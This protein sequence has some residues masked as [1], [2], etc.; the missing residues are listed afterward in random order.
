LIA[1]RKKVQLI[2]HVECSRA[3]DTEID[4]ISS[5]RSCESEVRDAGV[6]LSLKDVLFFETHCCSTASRQCGSGA[7]LES[8][9]NRH[10]DAGLI[11]QSSMYLRVTVETMATVAGDVT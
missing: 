6:L 4:K 8:F 10:E 5:A 3:L 11:A 1:Q 2:E 9:Q 7:G